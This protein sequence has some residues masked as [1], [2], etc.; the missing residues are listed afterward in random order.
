M[1]SLNREKKIKELTL[2][3]I[4][5]EFQSLMKLYKKKWRIIILFTLIGAI[6]GFYFSI[7]KKNKYVA[8][9]TFAI[10]NDKPMILGGA[11]VSNLG[12]DIGGSNEDGVFSKINITQLFNSR[13]MIE[14]SLLCT[15]KIDDKAIKL[16]DLFLNIDK[17]AE[18]KLIYRF[19]PIKQQRKNFS[20]LQDSTL[21][22]IY[23]N[24][25]KDL[26]ILPNIENST[27]FKVEFTSKN[28]IF[29]KYFLD[30][31]V[32]IVSDDY[33]GIKNRKT[34]ININT[35][36]N[37][38]DSVNTELDIALINNSKYSS[39]NN[40][41]V[42]KDTQRN[43]IDIKVMSEVLTDLCKQLELSKSSVNNDLSL[44]QIIDSPILPLEKRELSY[45]KGSSI[46]L[47]VG[48]FV[49]LL[50]LTI[51]MIIVRTFL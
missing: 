43:Q 8:E 50:F 9:L 44:I 3:E 5:K 51:K 19:F 15:V 29:A 49:G 13:K 6:S 24:I 34:R 22:V 35:L 27:I 25:I 39:L 23:K 7:L 30:S 42:K 1:A 41:D 14:K 12:F 48:L 32:K 16:A 10:Q 2:M 20:R 33:Y 37:L 28:E 17:I 4:I 45:F 46:G 31:L 21:G 18:N 40:K 26:I 11:L 36:K 38:I 47:F